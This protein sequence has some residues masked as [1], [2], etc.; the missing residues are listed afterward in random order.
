MTQ[1]LA[2]RTGLDTSVLQ[3]RT[4]F[5]F[6]KDIAYGPTHTM[7]MFAMQMEREHL[8]RH[9]QRRLSRRRISTLLP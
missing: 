3:S 9:K 1:F 8:T 6:W 4:C 2:K 5:L 7:T